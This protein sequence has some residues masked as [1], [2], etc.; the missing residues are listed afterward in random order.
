[1]MT[2]I[3]E[4]TLNARTAATFPNFIGYRCFQT[5]DAIALE[6][7]IHDRPVRIGGIAKGSGMIHP[8]NFSLL[9]ILSILIVLSILSY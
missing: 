7:T 8:N 1:M 2:I 9:T 5:Q 6:T 4:A 3:R